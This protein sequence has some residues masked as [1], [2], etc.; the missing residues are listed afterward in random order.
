MAD[1][2]FTPTAT[3]RADKARRY[4]DRA[5]LSQRITVRVGEALELL[6][7]EKGLYDIIFSDIDKTDYTR[8]F[9]LALPRLKSGGL[10]IADNV[11]WKGKLRQPDPTPKP[12]P[13]PNS[14]K[15]FTKRR[16]CLRPSCLCAM[17]FPFA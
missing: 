5:G 14:T 9:R 7:E 1:A 16:N 6:S 17:E 15:R 2:W 8:V 12:G 10:L 3:A 4:F 11:L 13:S